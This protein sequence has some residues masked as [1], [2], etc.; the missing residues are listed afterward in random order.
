MR[1]NPDNLVIG[2]DMT[3]GHRVV[4]YFSEGMKNPESVSLKNR[5]NRYLIPKD[6]YNLGNL[7]GLAKR[8][9]GKDQVKGVVFVVDSPDE[10]TLTGLKKEMEK[11]SYT[12]D[13]LRVVGKGES[14]AC[15]VFG[16]DESLRKNDVVMFE[17]TQET[18]RFYRMKTGRGRPPYMITVEEEDLSALLDT[19]ML[20]DGRN[21]EYCD[22]VFSEI[23]EKKMGSSLV[24]S[25]YL[26]GSGFNE[27]WYSKSLNLLCQKRRVFLGQNLLS[28]GAC[29]SF[30]N[31][32]K[33]S[34]YIMICEG[35]TIN[36]ISVVARHKGRN[37]Q[38]P[39]S[40]AG[41]RWYE[42]RAEIEG[43]L[44]TPDFLEFV[45]SFPIQGRGSH[46]SV[47]LEG[48]PAR[49]HKTTRIAICTEYRNSREFSITIKD[50]GFGELFKSS[51]MVVKKN[52][53][54]D[55]YTD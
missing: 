55:E 21:H 34:D 42:A 41:V 17:L 27:K 47:S 31:G 23:I 45:L 36:A 3:G 44:D 16:Q 13:D 20:D 43:I 10:D 30:Q 24:S 6:K 40:E 4:S 51:G 32:G 11:L 2:I 33:M 37:I 50:K 14:F 46:L 1:K 15:Y 52:V 26:V 8:T 38:V 7:I 39:L 54:A 22:T 49:P 19:G 35:R 5:E 18:F 29:H 48:F 9:S 53:N 25:I 28:L 12:K